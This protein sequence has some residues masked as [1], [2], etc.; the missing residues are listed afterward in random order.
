MVALTVPR[1]KANMD[2]YLQEV[3]M[4][5]ESITLASDVGNAVLMSESEYI[6]L[7]GGI[8]SKLDEADKAA[9]NT[10]VR[11]T[12]EEVFGRLKNRV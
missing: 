5:G 9:E 8:E 4:D 3:F 10:S 11:Y 1:F 7:T 12:H 2:S 6:A